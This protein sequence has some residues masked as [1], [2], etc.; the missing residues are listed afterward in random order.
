MAGLGPPP[1]S[2]EALM[3]NVFPS[4]PR[5][6]LRLYLF[7]PKGLRARGPRSPRGAAPLVRTDPPKAPFSKPLPVEMKSLRKD[8]SLFFHTTTARPHLLSLR[9]ALAALTSAPASG[10]L[11]RAYRSRL[12]WRRHLT[13]CPIYESIECRR[14]YSKVERSKVE[15]RKVERSKVE[16]RKVE[17]RKGRG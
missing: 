12:S 15:G 11:C 14:S 8:R 2:E 1:S 13:D 9:K 6:R 7:R 17:G 3:S 5:F 4:R 16:G 10:G